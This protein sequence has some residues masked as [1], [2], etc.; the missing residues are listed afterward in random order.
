MNWSSIKK[1]YLKNSPLFFSYFS[2][3]RLDTYWYNLY[4]N[5]IHYHFKMDLMERRFIY[6]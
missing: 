3:L 1:R 6:L 5:D 2:I 4:D